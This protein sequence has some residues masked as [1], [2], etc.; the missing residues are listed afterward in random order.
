[1]EDEKKSMLDSDFLFLYEDYWLLNF[2]PEKIKVIKV[3]S[4]VEKKVWRGCFSIHQE[5]ML[6]R[7]Y[8][9]WI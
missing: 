8:W 9:Y 6:R 4:I 5:I 1:M 7:K 2:H 3:W